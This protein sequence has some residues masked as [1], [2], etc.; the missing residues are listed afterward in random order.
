MREE[1]ALG[2]G[3]VDK[4]P[5]EYRALQR[6]VS[7]LDTEKDSLFLKY[8]ELSEIVRLGMKRIMECREHLLSDMELMEKIVEKF[9][10]FS[11][12]LVSERLNHL[13]CTFFFKLLLFKIPVRI[14]SMPIKFM[15]FS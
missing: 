8:F 2:K 10:L 1:Y 4:Y 3:F 9:N 14:F 15:D 7:N 5:E 6:F 13:L 11:S 12:N